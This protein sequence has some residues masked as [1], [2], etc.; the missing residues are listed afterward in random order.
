[1]QVKISLAWDR[2]HTHKFMIAT[3][4]QEARINPKTLL[5]YKKV[6]NIKKNLI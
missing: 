2:R 3:K 5:S 6:G 1:M 4:E